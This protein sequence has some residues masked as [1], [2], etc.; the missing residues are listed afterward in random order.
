M[1]ACLL[2]AVFFQRSGTPVQLVGL[3]VPYP[4]EAA[5]VPPS[6]ARKALVMATAIL[7]DS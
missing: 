3:P 2:W 6:T 1:G 4:R 5:A 7:S